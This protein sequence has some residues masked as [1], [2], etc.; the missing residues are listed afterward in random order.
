LGIEKSIF[1][2]PKTFHLTVLMLKLWN[3]E[4]VDTAVKIFE[5][6]KE[7]VMDALDG[8]PVSIK[9]KGLDCMKGSLAKARVLYAPVEVL[10]GEERLLYA[11]S[12]LVQEKDAKQTLK[13]QN[14]LIQLTIAVLFLI[15][16]ICF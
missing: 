2:K 11:C 15:S 16:S 7:E 13:V 12:G 14:S 9:L 4:R 10:G 8:Q 6:I 5:G 1:I 3:K